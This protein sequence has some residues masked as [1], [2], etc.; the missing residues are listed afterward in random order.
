MIRKYWIRSPG[1]IGR[2]KRHW[3]WYMTQTDGH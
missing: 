1:C 3:R 2:S